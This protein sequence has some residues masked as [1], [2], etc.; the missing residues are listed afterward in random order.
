M[1]TLSLLMG[2]RKFLI[3]VLLFS[4]V[5]L[6]QVALGSPTEPA[7]EPLM[8]EVGVTATPEGQEGADFAIL[9]WDAELGEWVE[10]SPVEVADGKV[11]VET[12]LMGTFVLVT[13]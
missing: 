11:S 5:M 4:A 10:L 6:C 7:Q 9:H 13:K 12:G 2:K 8:V 1:N 3:L